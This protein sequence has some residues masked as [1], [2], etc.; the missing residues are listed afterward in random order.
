MVMI[1]LLVVWHD[2]AYLLYNQQTIYSG[3]QLLF[4][5]YYYIACKYTYYC[6]N[7]TVIQIIYTNITG[8]E[9][10]Q[11]MVPEYNISVEICTIR[12][13]RKMQNMS[14]VISHY[15][16]CTDRTPGKVKCV[17]KCIPCALF[18]LQ[19][20]FNMFLFLGKRIHNSQ[21]MPI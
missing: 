21:D 3:Y 6:N 13:H 8:T 14:L 11:C 4:Y 10:H 2:V 20:N 17:L 7:M 1:L 18:C 5:L 16:Y 15:H 12:S 9:V 19:T